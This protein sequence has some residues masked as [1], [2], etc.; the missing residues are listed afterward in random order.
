[1]YEIRFPH[2]IYAV[3]DANVKDWTCANVNVVSYTAPAHNSTPV[4]DRSCQAVFL[5]KNMQCVGAV[6]LYISEC[7]FVSYS[8]PFTYIVA[9]T[10]S[11]T[12]TS[13]P[14]FSNNVFKFAVNVALPPD[15]E[16]S[17]I[18]ILVVEPRYE[19]A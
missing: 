19:I 5:P 2:G 18:T 1:M 14:P 9:F 6:E 16:N 3:N 8:A 13:T 11:W 10:L 15:G 7:A 12:I 17:S 4:T